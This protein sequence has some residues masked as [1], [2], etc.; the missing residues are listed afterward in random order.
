[1]R[2]RRIVA[3]PKTEN[4]SAMALVVMAKTKMLWSVKSTVSIM[5]LQFS[6]FRARSASAGEVTCDLCSKSVFLQ[7][8]PGTSCVFGVRLEQMFLTVSVAGER[9]CGPV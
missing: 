2:V 6:V 7:N 9:P 3:N 1:M 4:I 5:G 8:N